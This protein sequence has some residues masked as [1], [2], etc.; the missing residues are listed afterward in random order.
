MIETAPFGTLGLATIFGLDKICEK[1]TEFCDKVDEGMDKIMEA[2]EAID[3]IVFGDEKQNQHKKHLKKLYKLQKSAYKNELCEYKTLMKEYGIAI[4]ENMTA[5][6]LSKPHLLEE[7]RIKIL[8]D[9]YVQELT[10]ELKSNLLKLQQQLE[11]LK[12]FKNKKEILANQEGLELIHKSAK[13]LFEAVSAD[14]D[15]VNLIIQ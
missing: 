6:K 8:T 14:I 15:Q 3:D 1:D 9:D 2:V 12:T 4:D 11:F 5:F 7:G 13:A 10:Q